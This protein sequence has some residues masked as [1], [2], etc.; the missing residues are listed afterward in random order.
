MKQFRDCR[1][2]NSVIMKKTLACTAGSTQSESTE[3]IKS[4]I[5]NLKS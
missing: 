1:L 4:K 3:L 2:N 5:V